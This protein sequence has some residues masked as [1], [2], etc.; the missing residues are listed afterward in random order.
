MYN[1]E[2][3][4]ESGYFID[5]EYFSQYYDLIRRNEQTEK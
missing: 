4:L 1:R 5:N 2:E 3:L